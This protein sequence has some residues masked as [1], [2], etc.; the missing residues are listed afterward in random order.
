L[1]QPLFYYLAVA[2]IYILMSWSFYLPYR[3]GQ[4]HFMAVA[5]MEISAYIAA[6]LA[7]KLGFPFWLV[8]VIGT[9][10]GAA[11][12]FVISLGIGAAPCFSVV[13]VGFTVMYL[14]KTVI[15]NVDALGGPLGIFD[16]PK[17]LPQSADNRL[18]LL[19]VCLVCVLVV[20]FF[21]HR[22]EHSRLGRAA[23]SIFV[24]RNIAVSQGVD[25]K[26]MGI[27]LQTWSSAIGGLSGVL[28]AFVMR[29]ISP[30][31]FT[32]S[33]VGTCMTMLFVGGYTTPW[34]ILIATPVLWGFPLVLPEALQSWNIVIYGILLI[35]VL[36]IRPEGL[37]RRS[38]VV[39]LERRLGGPRRRK[40]HGEAPSSRP[41]A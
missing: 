33:I 12:G 31:H 25:V 39:G 9:L 34:G 18:L 1:S 22:F 36:V 29:S 21:V 8:L 5:N 23:S 35:F 15:E 37:V 17:V 20:G 16:I 2:A 10:I 40:G 11:L 3:V 19:G 32:F 26:R 6:I 41:G 14:A 27:F 38:F 28:Y 7:I 4:L 24:D 13:I 30:N